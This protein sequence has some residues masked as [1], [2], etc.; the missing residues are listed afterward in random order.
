MIE[1]YSRPEMTDLWSEDAKYALW[2]EI[3][4][5]ALASM[6]ELGIAPKESLDAVKKRAKFSAKRIAEIEAE[7]K[8][9]V[10]AFL[11]NITES[12]GEEARFLH[13]GMTSSDLLDTAFS[14]Q[15]VKATDIILKDV[16]ALLDAVKTRAME[17]KLTP[18]IGRSHGIHAE[19][20]TFGI[21]LAGHYAELLRQRDRIRAA[22]GEIAVGAISGPVGTYAHLSSKVETDVCKAFGLK[23]ASQSTQIICRDIHANLFL[24]FAQLATS[25]ERLALEIR[26]LQRTEVREA[27]ESFSKGQKGSSAMPH[28]KNPV[29]SENVT[30]LAR[31]I[32]ALATSTLDN[33]PT[34]HERDISHS[35]VERFA[36]P[37]ITITLDF[38]IARVTGLIANLK[39]YTENMR[40][41]LDLTGGLIHSGT[42]LPLLTSKGLK[43]ED[44]YKLVQKH[45]MD[46]WE[47]LNDGGQVITSFEA[48]MRAEKEI[49]SRFTP[50][51]LNQI[52][53][54]DKHLAN[55]DLIFERVFTK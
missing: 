43:R 31:I 10:I 5:A 20:T 16:D 30:G 51:E 34:W 14:V 19:P 49:N 38:M 46:T 45:A 12:V 15:L 27:E 44:A 7:T 50:Q 18:C 21:K 33:I 37:D 2:L 55:V 47:E 23:P 1:R 4:T 24:T 36:A 8:H 35:S 9:D 13:F 39:V 40:R 53:S 29:L 28:K 17:H 26:H 6:V 41:N 32:R 22:K 3:E 48:R 42:L 25:I 52:F 54:L 11:T